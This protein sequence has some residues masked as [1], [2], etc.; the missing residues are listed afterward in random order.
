MCCV[1]FGRY[2]SI[3]HGSFVCPNSTWIQLKI[4]SSI[5]FFIYA[6]LLF[7]SYEILYISNHF[8]TR[9][10]LNEEHERKFFLI[11]LKSCFQPNIWQPQ[12]WPVLFSVSKRNSCIFI[13][14]WYIKTIF[15]KLWNSQ[16]CRDSHFAEGTFV[17]S[18]IIKTIIMFLGHV[19]WDRPH[20]YISCPSISLHR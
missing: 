17:T 2:N 9:K 8:V 16:P 18:M 1:H 14:P 13:F 6:L 4:K 11:F 10:L 20:L 7:V 15:L 3:D 12:S 19:P 5:M